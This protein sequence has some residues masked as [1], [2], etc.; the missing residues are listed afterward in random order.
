MTPAPA[1]KNSRSPF[2]HEVSIEEKCGMKNLTALLTGQEQLRCDAKRLQGAITRNGRFDEAA[3]ESESIR[4]RTPID[5]HYLVMC[6]TIRLAAIM[7][8][9]NAHPKAWDELGR[10]LV[11]V[12]S[13]GI[14]EMISDAGPEMG[15]L[16]ANL[17]HSVQLKGTSI[18]MMAHAK[19]LIGRWNEVHE[20][21]ERQSR[22]VTDA[23]SRREIAIVELIGQGHSNKEIARQLGIAPETVK[24]HVKRIFSKLG[25]ERRAQAVS[26]AHALG[27]MGE[28]APDVD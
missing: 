10:A 15:E 22:P 21:A 20:T 19:K 23:L 6:I 9:G 18:E 13:T 8:T 28:Y 25:V 3:G 27:F 1:R 11:L 5:R 4:N 17:E 16:F 12:A 7:V 26:R 2:A 14:D 24:T